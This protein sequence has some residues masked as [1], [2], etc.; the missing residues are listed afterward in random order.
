M[1]ND[2]TVLTNFL[3]LIFVLFLFNSEVASGSRLV[4]RG[5]L[6]REFVV[7]VVVVVRGE[8]NGNDG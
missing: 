7:F 2:L 1:K 4:A 8:G 3:P 6:S 5:N